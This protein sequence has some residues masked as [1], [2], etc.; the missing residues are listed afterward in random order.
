MYHGPIGQLLTDM[1]R[2]DTHPLSRREV[3]VLRLLAD[4]LSTVEIARELHFSERTIKTV[5]HS[6][7]RRVAARNRTHAVVRAMRAG[8][9]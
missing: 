6:V 4:G 3:E 1:Y 5:V 8:L 2:V 7:T 9:I